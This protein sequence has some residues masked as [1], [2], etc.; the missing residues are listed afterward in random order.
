MTAEVQ[1]DV[2]A[3]AERMLDAAQ[4]K[5]LHVTWFG[6]EPLLAADVIEALSGRMM[7]LCE[8]KGA[9]YSAGIITNGYLLTLENEDLL[10]RCKVKSA[11]ITLD[12]VGEAIDFEEIRK[13]W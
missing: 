12:G 9:E 3:L 13:N 1:D 8:A 4:K 11:Q 2:I 5:T 7:A 10:A 6:G